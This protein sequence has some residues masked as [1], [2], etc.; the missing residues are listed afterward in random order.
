[1]PSPALDRLLYNRETRETS[2]NSN[3]GM[4][5]PPAGWEVEMGWQPSA[6]DHR[7]PPLAVWTGPRSWVH[8][9]EVRVSLDAWPGAHEER[10]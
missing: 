4:C 1:M 5:N 3:Y 8:R 10:P 2:N 7:P 9:D 6:F